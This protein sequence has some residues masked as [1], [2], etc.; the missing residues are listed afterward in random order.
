MAKTGNTHMIFERIVVG[1]HEIA[2]KVAAECGDLHSLPEAIVLD[3]SYFFLIGDH[4]STFPD[5]R[6][7]GPAARDLA[8]VKA[9]FICR[10][11][12]DA[13]VFSQS[14]SNPS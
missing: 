5:S 1:M 6:E 2:K 4:P 8:Y 9:I 10:P 14:R 13:G 3:D 7:F 12:K 11:T